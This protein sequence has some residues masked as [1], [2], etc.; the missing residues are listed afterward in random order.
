MKLSHRILITLI[1]ALAST[2]LRAQLPNTDV[3]APIVNAAVRA[4]F[5]QA[6][7]TLRDFRTESAAEF[8]KI[9]NFHESLMTEG[10]ITHRFRTL[11][12]KLVHCIEIGS[13]RSVKNAGLDPRNIKTSPAVLPTESANARSAPARSSD[14][15]LDGSLDADGNIRKCPAGSIPVLIPSLQDLYRFKRFEDLFRK[16]PTGRDQISS[17]PVE[18]ITKSPPPPGPSGSRPLGAGV[19][20]EYAHAYSIIDN[21][22]EQANFNLWQPGVEQDNEFSLS[23]LWVVPPLGNVP[24]RQSVETGWQV[25]R[26]L[27]GDSRPHL[28]IYSTTHN[29]E[30]GF[31]GG[32]NLGAGLFVQTDS[33]IIIG[34]GFTNVSTTGG[35]QYSVPLMYYR[36]QGGNHAWG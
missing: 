4:E 16:Y 32:Y 24:A 12:G 2:S 26:N 27:Y 18:Q 30:P 19:I 7:H 10:K 25:C 20:H 9:R 6:K 3:S 8:V 15:G 33:T 29:Y 13:Q 23:Q 28:F 22:G 35:D 14:F 17:I 36:D 5:E 31:P 21:Q 1:A 34:G 11:D